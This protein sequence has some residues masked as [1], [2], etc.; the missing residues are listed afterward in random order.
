MANR[1]SIAWGIAEE[2]H[3]Q[4][5]VLAFTYQGERV[6][7][8]VRE[9]AASVGSELCVEMDARDHGAAGGEDRRGQV[10]VRVGVG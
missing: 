4:G 10:A 6:E 3:R 2:L 7:K 9:L 1:R 5:A 8:N